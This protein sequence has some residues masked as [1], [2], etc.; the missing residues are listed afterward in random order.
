MSDQKCLYC[1]G[2]LEER[3]VTRLQ[4]Y[5]GH[6]VVIENLPALVCT[7][8]GETFFTPDAHD[9]VVRIITAQDNPVR[10]EQVPV[11]DARRAG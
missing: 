6:W 5:V 2:R 1:R 7:Q 11:Y 10:V 8:C 4:F 3:L 9:M